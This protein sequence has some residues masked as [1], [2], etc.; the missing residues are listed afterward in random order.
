MGN[1]ILATPNVMGAMMKKDSVQEGLK[2]LFSDA[3]KR[4]AITTSMVSMTQQT[5]ALQECEVGSVYN[6]ALAGASLNLPYNFGYWYAIPF[7]NNKKA[8]SL[9][10]NEYK[11]AQFQI[12]YK[13]LI[14]L[15]LRSNAYSKINAVE[16]KEGEL[17]SIDPFNE[18]IELKAISD[19][20]KRKQAKTIGYYA[21]FELKDSGFQKKVFMSIE[22]MLNHADNYSQAFNLKS[23]QLLQ[24]G[25][26]PQKDM[27][28]FSSFWY[29]N[30][31]EM[32]LKTVLKRLIS[33]W[34]ILSIE[35]QT[36]I[37]LDQAVVEQNENGLKPNYVD[38]KKTVDAE[39]EEKEV[40]EIATA[41]KSFEEELAKEQEEPK[42]MKLDEV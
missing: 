39:F 32:A 18:I 4:E 25:K 3:R 38:D 13:G 24:D 11:E 31:D 19:F 17:K 12:G 42:Q 1:L 41:N 28:K 30:F 36:A 27:W 2:A 35:M 14:Q 21:F 7:K 6:A 33:K 37:T 26:I 23:Y 16:V 8:R 34:G 22:E 9:G 5:P 40:S 15:A 10:L 29:K 20:E